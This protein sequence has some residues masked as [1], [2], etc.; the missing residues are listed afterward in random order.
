MPG[1]ARGVNA[2]SSCPLS[3]PGFHKDV[4]PFDGTL[5]A[6]P[7]SSGPASK[8]PNRYERK[9]PGARPRRRQG[10][11]RI[12]RPAHRVTGSR[13]DRCDQGKKG[14]ESRHV[15]VNDATGRAFRAGGVMSDN[16]ACCRSKQPVN[17]EGNAWIKDLG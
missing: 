15:C 17:Q 11:A 6:S 12:L 5:D 7:S 3:Q 1:A 13:R 9:P 16:S 2:F 14:W 10:F 8:S 4:L